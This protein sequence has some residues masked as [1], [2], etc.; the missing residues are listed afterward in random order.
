MEAKPNDRLKSLTTFLKTNPRKILIILIAAA[1]AQLAAIPQ[2]S[3]AYPSNALYI[4]SF[5]PLLFIAGAGGLVGLVGYA[6]G[7]TIGDLIHYGPSLTLLIFDLTAFAF[8]GWLTGLSLKTHTG[9]GQALRTLIATIITGFFIIF[10]T[11]IGV[12][13]AGSQDYST[14]ST[15]YLYGWLPF[16][17]IVATVLS[18][19]MKPIRDQLDKLTGSQP[20]E[21]KEEKKPAAEK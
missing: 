10:I 3:T 18:Y 14:L 15:R 1:L 5:L 4:L 2:P 11:P 8:A 21:E 16:Y 9:F 12:N 19:W 6:L 17:I 20:K 7:A 13:L